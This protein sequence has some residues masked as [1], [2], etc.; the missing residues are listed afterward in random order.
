MSDLKLISEKDIAGEYLKI[1]TDT[2]VLFTDI[3]V[4]EIYRDFISEL[5]EVLQRDG[6]RVHLWK[7][8]RAEQCKNYQEY[9]KATE[10]CLEKGVHRRAHF[11]AFGGGALSDFAGFVASTCLRGVSWSVIPT[12]LLS[13]I[14]ASIG[15]KVAINSKFGKNLIGAFHLPLAIFISPHFLKT[16]DEQEIKSGK[17]EMLKYFFLDQSIFELQ[18]KNDGRPELIPLLIEACAQFKLQVTRDDLNE[19]GKRKIL[20]LGHTFG[21]AIERIY[22][23]PHGEAVFW[24][25]VIKFLLFDNG[26]EMIRLK[27]LAQRIG[28]LFD[29]SPWLNKTI[30]VNLIFDYVSRDKKK[31]SAPEIEIIHATIDEGV[32]IKKHNV[33]D[34]KHLFEQKY[35]KIRSFQLDY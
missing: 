15:G 21:H 28:F 31:I 5:I 7:S 24:G 12:T 1:K 19:A 32:S 3:Y 23:I 16:L 26:P 10:F 18:Q 25:M 33:E 4:A 9:I 13:M 22:K 2:F 20:N 11:I 34:L 35:Q 6:R 17:G 8:P 14:D 27:Q 29:E 30:D